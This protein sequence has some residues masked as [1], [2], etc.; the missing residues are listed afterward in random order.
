MRRRTS[1]VI[2]LLVLLLP[3]STFAPAHGQSSAAP[4]IYYYSDEINAFIIERADGTDTRILGAGLMPP[5]APETLPLVSGPGWSPSGKWFAWNFAQIG[6]GE[7]RTGYD[8]IL[9]YAVKADG[10]QRLTLLDGLKNVEMTWAPHSDLLFVV[11][12]YFQRT[13]I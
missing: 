2:G 4:Y 5:L 13:I 11:S 7:I 9:P 10:S 1:F 3:F 6:T 12:Q 8:N